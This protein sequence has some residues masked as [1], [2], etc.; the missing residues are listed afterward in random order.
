[1]VIGLSMLLTYCLSVFSRAGIPYDGPKPERSNSE[2]QEL[3]SNQGTYSKL[4]EA[5]ARVW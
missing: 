5:A 3:S 1:M 4:D 2:Q